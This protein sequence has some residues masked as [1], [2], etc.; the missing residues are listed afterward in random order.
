MDCFHSFTIQCRSL[1]HMPYAIWLHN[2]DYG[3]HTEKLKDIFTWRQSFQF[4]HWHR[5]HGNIIQHS[6]RF[7]YGGV[8]SSNMKPCSVKF[9]Y[10]HYRVLIHSQNS[11][12]FEIGL[13]W[14]ATMILALRH[15]IIMGEI[16]LSTIWQHASKS[17]W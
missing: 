3:K 6:V 7:S 5:K 1:N 2:D 13:I 4:N 16:D 10:I 14:I 9:N 12:R 15:V 8:S 11:K 17:L